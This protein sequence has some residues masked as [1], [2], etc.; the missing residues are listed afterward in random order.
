[1]SVRLVTRLRPLL[2]S[3]HESD[4]IVRTNNVDASD[5]KA[6]GRCNAIPMHSLDHEAARLLYI[7]SQ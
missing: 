7:A 4:T 3:E 2:K 1:M 6:S 5:K